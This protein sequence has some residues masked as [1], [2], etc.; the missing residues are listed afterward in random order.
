[1]KNTSHFQENLNKS[2]LTGQVSFIKLT[3]YICHYYFFFYFSVVVAV[4]FSTRIFYFS[5]KQILIY[6]LF[7]FRKKKHKSVIFNLLY[8]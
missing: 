1:M 8:S 7:I 5:N 2:Q 3:V 4:D 6:I